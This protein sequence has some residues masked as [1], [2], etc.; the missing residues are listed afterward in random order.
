MEDPGKDLPNPRHSAWRELEGHVFSLFVFNLPD[1]QGADGPEVPD[2]QDLDEVIH[3][4]L[5]DAADEP[6][7]SLTDALYDLLGYHDWIRIRP[8]LWKMQMKI[9]WEPELTD[10]EDDG[11]ILEEGY[12]Y[13]KIV[14]RQKV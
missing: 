6:C 1:D 10:D 11:A 9:V 5:Y 14:G 12:W 8:G 13:L 7:E 3:H 2:S 4:F